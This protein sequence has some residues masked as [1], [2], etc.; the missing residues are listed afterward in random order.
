MTAG[1]QCPPVDSSQSHV[2]TGRLR[3]RES[4]GQ[5][6]SRDGT[7]DPR[8]FWTGKSCGH[9]RSIRAT[10]A[11]LLSLPALIC[12]QQ[13]PE[14][15]PALAF[16]TDE[17]EDEVIKLSPFEVTVT[18]NEGYDAVT[19]LV[20]NRLN[21]ELRDI[22]NAVQ[23]VTRQFLTDTA[24]TDNQTL[25]QYTTNTEVGGMEGNY[26]GVGDGAQLGE[27][28]NLS[29][30]D[31]VTR[32][33]G[34]DSPDNTRDLFRSDIPWD[35]YNIERV[36][37]QRGPNSILF[38]MGS[39]AGV[40]NAG[41]KSAAFSNFGEAE[42]RFGSHGSTR[43]SL[44]LNRELVEGQLALRIAALRGDEQFKQDPAFERDKR[45]YAAARWEPRYRGSARTILKANYENGKISAN[46]PRSIPPEDRLTPWFNTGTY[47]GSYPDG[48]PRTFS[49]LNRR[50]FNAYQYW[51]GD[52][53]RPW[54]G[55]ANPNLE[56]GSY[57]PWFSPRVS[58]LTR[59][60]D[61]TTDPAACFG[62]NAGTPE[63]MIWE[64]RTPRWIDA[65]GQIVGGSGI[66]FQ[67]QIAIAPY[68]EFAHAAGLPFSDLGVYKNFQLTDPTI[69]DFYHDLLDGPNKEEWE[70]FHA[71]NVS[72][73]QTFMNDSCGVELVVFGESHEEGQLGLLSWNSN[74]LL[75]DVMGVY[76]DG[77]N[78]GTGT[79]PGNLPFQDGTPNPNVGRPFIMSNSPGGHSVETERH[80]RRATAFVTHDF[81]R[82][83]DESWLTRLLGRHTITGL[84]ASDEYESDSR[85]WVRYAIEDSGYR[86]FLG[87][88]DEAGFASSIL[89]PDAFVYLG[90][91]LIDRTSAAGAN[92]PRIMDRVS[93]T[94][95]AVRAFDSTWAHSLD[96]GAPDYVDPSADWLDYSNG[97]PSTQSQNPAN[98]VGWIDFPVSV[99]DSEAAPG[100][101]ERL[102]T[103]AT[104]ASSR[105]SSRAVVWQGHFWDNAVVGTFGWRRDS[106]KS[107][108]TSLNAESSD[109]PFGHL[110]FGPSYRLPAEP[111]YALV[112]QSR[113]FGIVA[114]VNQLP[115]VSGRAHDWPVQFSLFYSRSTNFQPEAYR[116]DIYGEPIPPPQGTTV[117]SGILLE[118]RD[119]RFAV[120]INK[121]KSRVVDATSDAAARVA[122]N[123]GWIQ[124]VGA[125]W[126]NVFEYDWNGF[127]ADTA[128][129]EPDPSWWGYWRYNYQPAPGETIDQAQARE[130]AAIAAW[131]QWQSSVD[132][133]FYEA[134][135]IDL[136]DLAGFTG[137][138]FPEGLATTEDRV[139]TG[140]EIELHV[141][142]K[143]SWRVAANV[144]KCE[145][146]RSNI[147]G[148]ALSD[149]V[150]RFED[151]LHN[152]AAGDLRLWWGNAGAWTELNEW[153]SSSGAEWHQR[154]LQEGS[155]V[156]ELREWRVNVITNYDFTAGPLKGFSVGGGVRWQDDV[157]IGYPPTA[158]ATATNILFDLDHP[159]RGPSETNVDFWVGYHRRLA[160]KVDWSIQLNVR[161]AF[162]GDEL[163]PITVQPDGTPAGY[164]IAPSQ[165]W[166]V[167]NRLSF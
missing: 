17:V 21:T 77:T 74:A 123:L 139:S 164:R 104:L 15:L 5:P 141:R 30:P 135:S 160:N 80:G 10:F 148:A 83:G 13:V 127:G 81:T 7:V 70:D 128:D 54:S 151:A 65:T 144:S 131:R 64:S 162:A 157:V 8:T 59:L 48:N 121:F 112:V 6:T 22:G 101:R 142:P 126:A 90:P 26:A 66:P 116:I 156:P 163:I 51:F 152:T 46:R 103:S 53:N 138:N 109:L 69:F 33:R 24:A 43:A 132:P 125:T 39:P 4:P 23:I 62:G 165:T 124:T 140:Y 105:V 137:F 29:K 35:S 73:A 28:G 9:V 1:H 153:N 12:A 114:H 159:Y 44:D 71:Y 92:I 40:I 47:D 115:F 84:Y 122:L 61:E 57:N 50:T 60:G 113:S 150:Q 93:M 88:P 119:G 38:G 27:S 32:M 49:E 161:N 14:E 143:T 87:I 36:E 75:V 95:G 96:P 78:L 166:T 117:D 97:A 133:R 68:A 79:P 107:W 118:S 89:L 2:A 129:P 72:L 102:A 63:M 45:I 3:F 110:D 167:T 120:K 134:W 130:T 108:K 154:K 111:G 41:L 91:S 158:D 145:A 155:A 18:A 19:T 42:F 100:N 94:S 58:V 76:P 67:R 146:V 85:G 106:A 56:D 11:A 147:G 136:G 20:G 37:L 99:T 82:D 16:E 52:G 55:V 34:L 31:Q 25:L 149:F 98:Y 86:D